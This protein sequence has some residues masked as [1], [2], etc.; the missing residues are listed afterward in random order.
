MTT[1]SSP[2][3]RARWLPLGVALGATALLSTIAPATP[4][5]ELLEDRATLGALIRGS[6]SPAALFLERSGIHHE[7]GD[8]D[9]ALLDLDRA[10]Q[11]GADLS[12]VSLGRAEVRMSQS[13]FVRAE[14]EASAALKAN[15]ENGAAQALRG[16]SRMARGLYQ[17]AADDF[18]GAATLVA[19]RPL[20]LVAAR[21]EAYAELP[22]GG[23]VQALATIE[24]EL[25][26]RGPATS[27]LLIALQHERS[28]GH[29]A[30]AMERLETLRAQ[31]WSE[32]H[33]YEARGDVLQESG[34]P[35]AARTAWKMALEALAQRP[36]RRRTTRAAVRLHGELLSR[37]GEDQ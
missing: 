24:A 13:E 25:E 1:Q 18:G 15:P 10:L 36:T 20:D 32:A 8:F 19:R 30:A 5:S 3:S 14:K 11:F 2:R 37:L 31:G 29:F 6:Q 26:V 34:E 22:E 16:H 7:L 23:R 33:Y 4:H 21:A 9:A 27:L 35:R 28:L 17:L 12:D